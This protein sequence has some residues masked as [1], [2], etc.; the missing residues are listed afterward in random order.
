MRARDDA[1]FLR[2][3]DAG[4]AHE[5]LD[6]GFICAAR[7]RVREITGTTRSRAARRRAHGTRPR[8]VERNGWIAE[9]LGP[10]SSSESYHQNLYGR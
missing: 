2:S 9:P 1:K 4:E 6:G 3:A 7:A 8:L 5:V 10:L